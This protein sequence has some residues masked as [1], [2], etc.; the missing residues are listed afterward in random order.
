MRDGF[1]RQ[2]KPE[3][4]DPGMHGRPHATARTVI[5]GE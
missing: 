2:G 1:A 4:I 5:E 3:T